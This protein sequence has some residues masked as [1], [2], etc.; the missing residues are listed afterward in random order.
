MNF[1]KRLTA[2]I[3][4][5]KTIFSKFVINHQNLLQ[6]EKETKNL[7]GEK[8]ITEVMVKEDPEKIQN[9]Q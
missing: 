1:I 3:F 4:D 2:Y 7:E 8:L 9:Q 6:W 5:F